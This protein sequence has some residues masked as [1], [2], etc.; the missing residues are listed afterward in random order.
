MADTGLFRGEDI[1]DR[2]VDIP[3]NGADHRADPLSVESGCCGAGGVGAEGSAVAG[4]LVSG[5]V[6]SLAA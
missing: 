2:P 1:Q 5:S 3:K 6:G 4:S